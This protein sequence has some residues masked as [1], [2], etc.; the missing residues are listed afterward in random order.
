MISR[1]ILSLRKAADPLQNYQSFGGSST[2]TNFRGLEFARSGR[3]A[4]EGEGDIS[5]DTYSKS[6]MTV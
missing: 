2:I 4:K 3:V 5:L 1:I 6:Q